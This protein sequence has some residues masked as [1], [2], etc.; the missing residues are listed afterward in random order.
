LEWQ[1]QQWVAGENRRRKVKLAALMDDLVDLLRA[2]PVTQAEPI[3][4]ELGE[5]VRQPRS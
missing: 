5:R 2:G 1:A 3:L 4:R